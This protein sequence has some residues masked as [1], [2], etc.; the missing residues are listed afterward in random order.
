MEQIKIMCH[1]AECSE[2]NNIIFIVFFFLV[3]DVLIKYN[4][5]EILDNL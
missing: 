3:K 4:Q 2:K 1:L 5:Q